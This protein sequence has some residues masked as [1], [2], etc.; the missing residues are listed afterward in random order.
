M[1]ILLRNA[2]GVIMADVGFGLPVECTNTEHLLLTKFNILA[3]SNYGAAAK[4]LERHWLEARI[5]EFESFCLPSVAQQTSQ[6]FTW[7]VFADELSPDWFRQYLDQHQDL[8]TPLYIS[9]LMMNDTVGRRLQDAGFGC[10][11]SLITSRLDNDD[12][13]ASAYIEEVQRRYTGQQLEFIDFPVGYRAYKAGLYGGLWRSNPFMSLYEQRMP[14]KPFKTV[15]F[16]QHHLIGGSERVKTVWSAPMWLRS[17]HATNTVVSQLG[18]PL[19]VNTSDRFGCDWNSIHPHPPIGRKVIDSALGYGRRVQ[20]S[21]K[22][23]SLQS[24]LGKFNG[25]SSV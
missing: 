7:V 2:K 25:D 23:R 1:L 10:G 12:A 24:R 3:T 14:G 5:R 20:R 6:N 18:L 19:L 9:G 15:Y 8:L 17:V 16:K 11:N 13:I 21:S 22:Y 4:R